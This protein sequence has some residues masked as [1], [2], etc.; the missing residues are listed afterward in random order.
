MSEPTIQNKKEQ[1]MTKHELDRLRLKQERRHFD[2]MSNGQ[3]IRALIWRNRLP[4]LTF[5]N[6]VTLVLV[7][8]F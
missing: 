1:K 7:I 8:V 6:V 4:L 5:S 3:V 2:S